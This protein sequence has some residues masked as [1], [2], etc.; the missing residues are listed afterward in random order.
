MRK[1]I[2]MA[3]HRG[4]SGAN[5][6]CNTPT[7]FE[8]ALLQGADIIELDV[9]SSSDGVLFVFHP[10]MEK[11]YLTCPTPIAQM[12]A[13]EVSAWHYRNQDGVLTH[14]GVSRLDDVLE[15]LKSRCV[16][17]VDKFWHAPQA[18]ADAIHR[19]NMAEQVIIKTP[20]KPEYFDAVERF[21]PEMAFMPVIRY[22]DSCTKML[23]KRAL[24]CIGAEVLFENDSDP[25]AC[26][27]YL[28]EMH[29]AGM[30]VWLNTIV[31]DEKEVISAGHTDDCAV[32]GNPDAGWGNLID[33]GFDIIQTDWCAM[34]RQYLQSREEQNH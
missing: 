14:Y 32:N 8:I 19:H 7:A 31:Y 17:N 6:P 24:H 15:Q 5:I 29:R 22:R 34:L 20:E 21:A 3:A 23:Q 18:I 26:P 13:K 25:V 10:G 4:V 9:A 30:D 11:P 2:K 27:E 16:V 33:R 28:E 1:K 12:T